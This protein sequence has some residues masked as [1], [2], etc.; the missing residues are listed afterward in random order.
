M[1]EKLYSSEWDYTSQAKFYDRRPNYAPKAI[2]RICK[3]VG[4]STHG[5]YAVADIGAGTGNLTLLLANKAAKVIAIE[6]ND[7]M[8]EIGRGKTKAMPNVEWRVGSGEKTG[9]PS[10]AVDLAAFGSSFNTTDRDASLRE[11]HRILKPE[12]FF[13]CMWNNRDLQDGPQKRVEEIIREFVP[14][15]SHGTRRE[16]QADVIIASRLFNNLYY[17]EE[18]QAVKMSV[19]NF[20]DGWRS[21]KNKYW[22]PATPEGKELLSKIIARIES[23]FADTPELQITYVTRAWTAKR[24]D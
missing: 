23:E 24:E 5:N 17:L 4:A 13:T 11:S 3:H 7:A 1:S 9:L 10:G 22:D 18:P 12:G 14:D 21:V 6:P 8:R 15:Y 19:E 2:E 20:V 16:Q